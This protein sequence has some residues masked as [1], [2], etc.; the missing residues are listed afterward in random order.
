MIPA[1]GL[2]LAG[3]FERLRGVRGRWLLAAAF[4][5]VS[6]LS[7]GLT[8]AREAVSEYRLFSADEARAAAFAEEHTPRDAVFLTGNQHN[9]AIAALAGRDIICGTGSYLYFHGIDYSRQ[10]E[11]ERR[12]LEA[13]G[14]SAALFAQYGVSYAYISSY[15]RR[16]F[17]V[18]EAWFDQNA[19][20][21]FGSGD[22]AIYRLAGGTASDFPGH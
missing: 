11:D 16:N 15:E 7:G 13:P 6:L 8:I 1:A 3:V 12:M 17:L 20:K 18:D 4:M 10:A 5:L 9:N 22:V 19:E 14:E 21:V 2:Y